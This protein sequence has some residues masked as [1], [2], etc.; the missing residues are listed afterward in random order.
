[1]L[2]KNEVLEIRKDFPYLS[3]KMPTDITYLDSAAT[4]Q[5][6]VQVLDAIREYYSFE[7][8]NPHRGAHYL[9]N[10][11]TGILETGRETVKEF[12]HAKSSEEII[13]TNNTTHSLNLIAYSWALNHL[14]EGD[15]IVLSIMEHHSNL[16]TW[17]WV[18]EKTKAK[19]VYLYIDKET[20]EIPWNEV[21]EKINERTKLFTITESSNVLG[22][23]P[24]VEKMIAYV[25]KNAPEAVTVVDGAQYAPHNKVDVQKLDCDFYVFSGHKL[26]S[27]MGIGVLYGKKELLN[28]MPP[29]FYGGEM[30]E[31]VYED[32]SSF[33]P[34]PLRFEAGTPDVAGV[35]ALAASIDYIQNIGIENIEAYEKELT[36]YAFDKVIKLDYLDVYTTPSQRRGSVID[37]NFKEVHPHDVASILDTYG[38]AIRSGHHCA[39]PLHRYL[40]TNF[41]CRASI[42]FYNTIEE[43]DYFI[44][45]LEDVR[46]LMGLGS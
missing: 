23:M 11:A 12:L 42:A 4:T 41:S 37:F 6:P 22:T 30:I 45:H 36:D 34:A 14:K 16:V 8:G 31:Y 10:K 26:L 5:K 20:K 19:L 3:D 13:F 32:R 7:N 18:A 33:L 43:V 27:P 24:D 1:M 29:F 35:K 40:K 44:E 17:Q 28:A 46:R 15:E 2:T 9:G 25:R 21:T 38:I 39:Q